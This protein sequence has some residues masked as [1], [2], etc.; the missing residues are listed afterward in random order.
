MTKNYTKGQNSQEILGPYSGTVYSWLE[1]HETIIMQ[2]GKQ[3]IIK[4]NSI[5]HSIF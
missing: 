5:I 4:P 2:G 3:N 1:M